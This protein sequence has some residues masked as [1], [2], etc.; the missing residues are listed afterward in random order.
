MNKPM[1]TTDLFNAVCDVLKEKDLMPTL[2]DYALA[3]SNP[4]PITN[5]EFELKNNLDY[6]GSEGI[7]LDLWIVDYK[8]GRTR[9]REL[10]TF[11]TLNDNADAMRIM[12]KLLADFIVEEHSYVTQHADDF[13]WEGVNVYAFDCITEKKLNWSYMCD[14]IEQ[15][16]IKKEELL[17][18]YPHVLIRDN[19][20]RKETVYEAHPQETNQGLTP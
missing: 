20:T 6:G 14:N 16:L 12:G 15:A 8:D 17:K 9:L 19:V 18:K 10:G 1:T 3:D 13:L 7:Y 11:K 2:L 4:S 5:Y